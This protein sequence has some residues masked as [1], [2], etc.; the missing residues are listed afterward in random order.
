MTWAC[1]E[2]ET[3]CRRGLGIHI[4]FV[5]CSWHPRSAKS[6]RDGA[7]RT[8][9]GYCCAQQL[10]EV[11]VSVGSGAFVRNSCHAEHRHT[12]VSM[13]IFSFGG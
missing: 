5:F 10:G 7:P 8:S 13:L 12:R 3:L 6:H 11:H 4:I 2:K 1:V 9:Y